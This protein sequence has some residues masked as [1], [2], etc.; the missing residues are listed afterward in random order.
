VLVVVL[1]VVE[2]VVVVDGF[3][4]LVGLE[5]VDVLELGGWSD[6]VVDELT[7]WGVP[8][9]E[10]THRRSHGAKFHTTA[11][12]RVVSATL[13]R[14][15]NNSDA[16]PAAADAPAGMH[17]RDGWTRRTDMRLPTLSD[18]GDWNRVAVGVG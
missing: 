15:H 3:V 1:V 10:G 8:S 2:V 4:V 5:L 6:V 14:K 11:R 7:V 9:L 16:P 17:K 18:A 12:R 13:T